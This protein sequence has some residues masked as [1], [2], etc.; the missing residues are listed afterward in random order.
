[1]AKRSIFDEYVPLQKT[2]ESIGKGGF[3]Y[4]TVMKKKN[5]PK[6]K[7]AVKVLEKSQVEMYGTVEDLKNE[8]EIHRSLDHP[9]IIKLYDSFEDNLFIYI[10]TEYA[11]NG[12][13]N[14]NLEAVGKFNEKDAFLK[15]SQALLGIDYL[16][17]NGIIHR[18]QKP[19]N[20]QIDE[21]RVIKLSDFGFSKVNDKGSNTG[22]VGTV[23]YM[24]PEILQK[25]GHSFPVDIW[26]LGILLYELTIGYCPFPGGTIREKAGNIC[27][28]A[29]LH[30]GKLNPNQ[31]DLISNLLIRQ[32]EKRPNL[33]YIFKHPWMNSF[34]E[35][36][37]KLQ[38]QRKYSTRKRNTKAI[39]DFKSTYLGI[40]QNGLNNSLMRES[41]Q[42][43]HQMEQNPRQSVGTG[44]SSQRSSNR[45]FF[46]F[47]ENNQNDKNVTFAKKYQDNL[48]NNKDINEETGEV[49]FTKRQE[50]FHDEQM[51]RNLQKE[52]EENK[53]KT[54]NINNNTYYSKNNDKPY[55]AN[56]NVK[57]NFYKKDTK[58]QVQ[59]E[60]RKRRYSD[61]PSNRS[62]EFNKPKD[63]FVS[64]IWNKQS[65]AFGCCNKR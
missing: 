65:T 43:I 51:R 9:Y 4:V 64:K 36:S 37:S 56:E 10:V 57:E 19:E 34:G 58:K 31:K 62:T 40:G 42:S 59:I 1:M 14:D 20:L 49:D 39:G 5:E 28:E 48:V 22:L 8:I 13:L 3:G 12:N 35:L 24:A 60:E 18:D 47:Q 15:F 55:K 27:T 50:A 26:A 2:G 30:L 25:T 53:R 61:A 6:K 21:N 7:F 16:H 29:P 46:Q 41:V 17:Y 32:K 33:D 23:D 63:N 38:N 44:R 52:P 54:K 11:T 45:D